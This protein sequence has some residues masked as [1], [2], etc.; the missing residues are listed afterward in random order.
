MQNVSAHVGNV[1]E[2]EALLWRRSHP[3]DRQI[4]SRLHE[5]NPG[6]RS[7]AIAFLALNLVC[8]DVMAKQQ[9]E[10]QS[11]FHVCCY[12][13]GRVC[14]G[15]GG[16]DEGRGKESD[17]QEGVDLGVTRDEDG[18]QVLVTNGLHFESAIQSK[19][20]VKFFVTYEV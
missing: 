3:N 18:D 11:D 5:A 16:E 12:Q 9:Q 1:E 7:S 13:R 17:G 14:G 6:P 15:E 19:G 4:L 2:S 8:T 20:V 10:A